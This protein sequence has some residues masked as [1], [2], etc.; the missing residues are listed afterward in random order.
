MDFS[1]LPFQLWK[2]SSWA[3]Q[4]QYEVDSADHPL[5]HPPLDISDSVV[6]FGDLLKQLYKDLN[7]HLVQPSSSL[8]GFFPSRC[9]CRDVTS[10]T[11]VPPPPE[12]WVLLS[13]P[14]PSRYYLVSQPHH[15][16]LLSLPINSIEQTPARQQP[17]SVSRIKETLRQAQNSFVTLAAFY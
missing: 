4:G 8:K 9:L 12:A 2:T 3:Y 10:P 5:R 16:F 11:A 14:S 13:H 6:T 7:H 15:P 1:F 17:G